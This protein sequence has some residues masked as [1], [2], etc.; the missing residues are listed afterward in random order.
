MNMLRISD[1]NGEA[2]S[3]FFVAVVSVIK[4]TLLMFVSSVDVGTDWRMSKI[5]AKTY[6]TCEQDN[7]GLYSTVANFNGY[8]H[9]LTFTAQ[10]SRG[11]RW[12][13][14]PIWGSD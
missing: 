6:T 7:V 3:D 9:L 1:V 14:L 12:I 13:G 10:S 8:K 11:D 4:G 5:V 2:S